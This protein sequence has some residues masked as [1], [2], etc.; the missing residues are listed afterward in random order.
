MPVRPALFLD[1][2]GV[3]IEEV[4]YLSQPSQ[5]SLIPG[6]AEAIALANQQKIPVVVA[7][8]QAG[9]ARGY[10]P[11]ANVPLVHAHL[12]QLLTSHG[13]H[14]D[15]YYYCPHHPSEGVGSYAVACTCRKPLPGMLLQAAT[16]LG[17]DLE[18]SYLVG[19]KVSD[20]Q[21]ALN[22]GCR[23]IL[24]QTGYGREH[25]QLLKQHGLTGMELARDLAH[26]VELCLPR[27]L[28]RREHG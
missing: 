8:N 21:A 15:R 22:A 19:D 3:I 4:D 20:L 26:A 10:F 18:A 11:E 24:V 25:A 17:L 28:N 16:D 27:L 5:V 14:I 12:D 13:A 23:A 7:T 9:V 2:D 6:A 1:R